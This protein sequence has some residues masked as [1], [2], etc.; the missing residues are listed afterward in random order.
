M[1]AGGKMSKGKTIALWVV[2][3]LLTGLFL[4]AGVPKLLKP[5]QAKTM[6]IG[7]GYAGWFAILIGASEALGAIGLLVPR[8]AALAAAGLSIIMVG[9]FFTHALHREYQHALVPLV[10]L[11][12]L[13]AVGYARFK[14]ARS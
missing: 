12:L 5:D 7:Y 1:W 10:L 9:A 13:V 2:S 11:S 8:L 6:F 3:I 14:E 4:S